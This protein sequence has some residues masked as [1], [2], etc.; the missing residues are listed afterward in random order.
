LNVVESFERTS[1]RARVETPKR[2]VTRQLSPL[3]EG[4]WDAA[5][6]G[7]VGYVPFRNWTWT[8]GQDSRNGTLL[9]M[10]R[11]IW[12]RLQIGHFDIFHA[13]DPDDHDH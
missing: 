8:F 1:D 12:G 3:I 4:L 10:C 2:Q 13:L 6:L 5:R 11:D 7:V 9:L